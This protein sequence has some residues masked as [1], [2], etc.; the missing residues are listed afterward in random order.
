MMYFDF[1]HTGIDWL[2]LLRPWGRTRKIEA[3]EASLKKII[4]AWKKVTDKVAAF[5]TVPLLRQADS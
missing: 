1:F 4:Y 3:A 5:C 2:L